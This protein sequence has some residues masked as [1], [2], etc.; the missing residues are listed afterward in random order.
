LFGTSD[1]EKGL[2]G[3]LFHGSGHDKMG[4]EERRIVGIDERDKAA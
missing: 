3:T 1:L 2:L 4:A